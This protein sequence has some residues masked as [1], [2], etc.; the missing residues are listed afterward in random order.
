MASEATQAYPEG[1]R[2]WD[3]A[4]WLGHFDQVSDQDPRPP[5]Y[6]FDF[7][8]PPDVRGDSGGWVDT[9][10]KIMVLNDIPCPE[11]GHLTLVVFRRW[12]NESREERAQI[13][14]SYMREIGYHNLHPQPRRRSA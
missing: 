12:N 1:S 4:Q 2:S 14:T 13:A 5:C 9:D 6:V 10:G 8:S 3:E 11:C 7:L